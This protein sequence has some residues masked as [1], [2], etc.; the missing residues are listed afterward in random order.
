MTLNDRHKLQANKR[1][2]GGMCGVLW[3]L[4]GDMKHFQSRFGFRGP[5]DKEPCDWCCCHR[6]DGEDPAYSQTN[7]GRGAKWKDTVLT[8]EQWR[9]RNP[10]LHIVFVELSYISNLNA[11]QDELHLMHLGISRP[12]LGSILWLL[13][14]VILS[15]S[16]TTNMALV[17]QKV[18]AYYQKCKIAN[19]YGNLSLLYF[20][21]PREHRADYPNL[22]G[23][24]CQTKDLI[25]AL[26]VILEEFKRP[27][28]AD[29][30]LL[31]QCLA[32]YF[33]IV[34]IIDSYNG[35]LFLQKMDSDR[36][37]ICAQEFLEKYAQLHLLWHDRKELLFNPIPKCHF[38]FHLADRSKYLNPR[39]CAT[40]LDEDFVGK[41][42]LIA[43][44]SYCGTPLHK[45]PNSVC[46]KWRHGFG[47]LV[48]NGIQ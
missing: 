35:E 11:C 45:V 39:A 1:S 42:K 5:T 43:Q 15:D 9:H 2:P 4:T 12:F 40:F 14:Y 28:N 21:S 47:M 23:K 22:K 13:V 19:Q 38:L 3:L 8:A 7:F 29:D 30:T 27:G 46:A 25:G 16:P 26:H 17:W 48:K 31:L 20:T 18:L 34:Q 10:D 32:S 41:V 33:E 37:V 44:R 6:I 36:M 24:G